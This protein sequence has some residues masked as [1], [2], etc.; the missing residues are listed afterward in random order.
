[1]S[2]ERGEGKRGEARRA[3][4]VFARYAFLL[5]FILAYLILF[6]F[7]SRYPPLGWVLVWVSLAVPLLALIVSG[8]DWRFILA[9]AFLALFAG[10]TRSAAVVRGGWLEIVDLLIYGT[11]IAMAPVAI[12][13]RVAKDFQEEGVDLEVILGA[14]CAYLFIGAWFA[15]L[16]RSLSIL[17][18]VPF[19][20]QAGEE[21]A[22]NHVY[23]SLVTLT[24]V[25]YG[26][27]TPAYALGRMLAVTEAVV[28]QLYLVS[29]V[30]LVVSQYR[31]RREPRP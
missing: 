28:G 23:F 3:R 27:L 21:D 24:T 15:F 8:E 5:P 7:Q 26:D 4:S 29:V 1:M 20:A 9:M 19:F 16:Y 18:G 2:A 30:A 14:L 10:A 22:L 12:L 17:L 6:G 13:R 11:L 31:G 25:G